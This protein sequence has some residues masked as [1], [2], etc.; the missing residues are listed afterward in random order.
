MIFCK[1]SPNIYQCWCVQISHVYQTKCWE[2]R[3]VL[4]LPEMCCF[5][6]RVRWGD[7]SFRRHYIC[8]LLLAQLSSAQH[9]S[10]STPLSSLTTPLAPPPLP[11]T[12]PPRPCLPVVHWLVAPAV[13]IL[14]GFSFF[15]AWHHNF[16]SSI[17]PAPVLKA[18]EGVS[19]LVVGHCSCR[20]TYIFPSVILHRIC[21]S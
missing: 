6:I 20:K 4:S 14:M 11:S 7:S 17:H 10:P 12:D 21:A 9:P 16:F 13:L 15:P 8:T 18:C 5:H 1:F 2:N 3:A 19:G